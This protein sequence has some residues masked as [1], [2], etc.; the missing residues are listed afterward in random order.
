MDSSSKRWRTFIVWDAWCF[1]FQLR[2]ALDLVSGM[3]PLGLLF[4]CL[5]LRSPTFFSEGCYEGAPATSDHLTHGWMSPLDQKVS[6]KIH[7]Q[8]LCD[9]TVSETVYFLENGS[10]DV[11]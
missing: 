7:A 9:L 10:L 1:G 5:D 8:H 4:H 6:G 3:P 11:P 2:L